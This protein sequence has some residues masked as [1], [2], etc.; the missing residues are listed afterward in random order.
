[1]KI[2]TYSETT[3]ISLYL[4]TVESGILMSDAN[5]IKKLCEETAH[6]SSKL[7]DVEPHLDSEGQHESRIVRALIDELRVQLA[8]GK[9]NA[10][11]KIDEIEERLSH[12][13]S[14][15]KN[16]VL[17]L[18]KQ[19]KS[20]T[21]AIHDKIH[22][23][24]LHLKAALTIAGLRLELAEQKSEAKLQSAK[25]ELIRDFGKI[26]DTAKDNAVQACDTSAKWINR[27]KIKLGKRAH[28][29]LKALKG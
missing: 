2:K 16:A 29:V 7:E 23:S 17:R 18:E 13:Y 11:E 3:N 25:D 4:D 24:W 10:S 20:E 1:M 9:M 14:K 6:A 21:D 27:T 28:K 26:R 12:G 5:S 19:G 22:N 8:L 15:I